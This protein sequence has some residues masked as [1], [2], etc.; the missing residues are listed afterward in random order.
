MKTQ[1]AKG[2][3]DFDPRQFLAAATEEMRK[4]YIEEI[5]MIAIRGS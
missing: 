2:G 1:L 3:G 4:L 5:Q